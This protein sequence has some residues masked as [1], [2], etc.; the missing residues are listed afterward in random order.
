VDPETELISSS[1][2]HQKDEMGAGCDTQ[3]EELNCIRGFIEK[4]EER[5]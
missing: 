2:S 1:S 3:G 5:H 4:S